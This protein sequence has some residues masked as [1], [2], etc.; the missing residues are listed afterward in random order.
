M[1]KRT[2]SILAE[3]DAHLIN[4][5]PHSFLE[6]KASNIIQG[7]INLI[8]Y[9]RENYD[10]D[11]AEELERRMLNSIR[12]QDPKKFSKAVSKLKESQK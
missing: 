1:Q 10:H 2:K 5:E 12:A 6:S 7:A 8:Q 11:T 3:L 4:R 9:I